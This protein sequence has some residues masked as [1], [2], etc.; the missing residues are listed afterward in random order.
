MCAEVTASFYS[1][2]SS[3][4][5]FFGLIANTRTL[6]MINIVGGF[7]FTVHVWPRKSKGAVVLALLQS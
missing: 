3:D 4:S 7:L 1:S 6:G 2:S 5:D